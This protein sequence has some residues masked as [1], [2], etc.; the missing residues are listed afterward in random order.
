[1]TELQGWI[2]MGLLSLYVFIWLVFG[3]FGAQTR[4][5]PDCQ[6]DPGA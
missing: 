1:M 5:L 6:L 4:P 2:L 3:I